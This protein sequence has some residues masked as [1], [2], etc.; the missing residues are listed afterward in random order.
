MLAR[1]TR[2][3]IIRPAL[4]PREAGDGSSTVA[5]RSRTMKI[6]ATSTEVTFAAIVLQEGGS[7]TNNAREV[8]A[9]TSY[10]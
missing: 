3:S 1:E 10:V 2:R 8:V 6:R 7:P 4:S 5:E 9:D